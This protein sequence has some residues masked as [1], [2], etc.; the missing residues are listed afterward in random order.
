MTLRSLGED[1]EALF[2]L[3]IFVERA[4]QVNVFFRLNEV[5]SQTISLIPFQGLSK[6][7]IDKRVVFFKQGDAVDKSAVAVRLSFP[8]WHWIGSRKAVRIGPGVT[9]PR[10]I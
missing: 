9:L 2:R 5:A 4:R 10:P 7:D 8:A 6:L 3:S 1:C